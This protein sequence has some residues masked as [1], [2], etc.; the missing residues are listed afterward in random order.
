MSKKGVYS[1]IILSIRLYNQFDHKQSQS[2]LLLMLYVWWWSEF[3]FG[4]CV[5][6]VVFY[7]NTIVPRISKFLVSWGGGG[8]HLQVSLEYIK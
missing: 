3:S 1:T 8:S 4:S 2:I 7:K 5:L 6:V